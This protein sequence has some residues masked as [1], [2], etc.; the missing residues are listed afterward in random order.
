[1]ENRQQAMHSQAAR[2]C[3][4]KDDL[5]ALTKLTLLAG[6]CV[7]VTACFYGAAAV[8]TGE[9]LREKSR[10]KTEY[11]EA[12]DHGYLQYLEDMKTSACPE[13]EYDLSKQL[14]EYARSRPPYGVDAG[15]KTLVSVY[16]DPTQTAV[17]RSEAAYHIA[18]VYLRRKEP[19]RVIAE[20]YLNSLKTE[21]PGTHDCVADQLL[22]EIAEYRNA[23]LTLQQPLQDDEA[24]EQEAADQEAG[25]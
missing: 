20:R 1:M 18:V 22:N 23:Q 3:V 21:F 5:A 13:H 8:V 6:L 12:L 19:N 2:R 7:S 17:V 15:I 11:V 24:S 10:T 25:E 4:I 14:F 9:A 16:E